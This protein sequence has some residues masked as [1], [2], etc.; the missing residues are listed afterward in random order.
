[1][2]ISLSTIVMGLIYFGGFTGKSTVVYSAC[3]LRGF[4]EL[5]LWIVLRMVT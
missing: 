5:I 3:Y 1:M 4:I 2:S